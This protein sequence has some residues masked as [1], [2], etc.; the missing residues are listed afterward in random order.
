MLDPL[1][2]PG[3]ASIGSAA[4]LYHSVG[5]GDWLEGGRGDECTT[6][7]ALCNTL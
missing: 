2:F 5:E 4:Y 7:I 3:E 6:Q 1:S